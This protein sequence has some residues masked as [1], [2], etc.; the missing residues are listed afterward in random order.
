MR[1]E[2][3]VLLSDFEYI[4]SL[5]RVEN[6]VLLSGFEYILSLLFLLWLVLVEVFGEEWIAEQFFLWWKGLPLL[7]RPWV[8]HS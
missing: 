6:E 1:V 3:E 7:H 5:L 2:N 8:S 4:L